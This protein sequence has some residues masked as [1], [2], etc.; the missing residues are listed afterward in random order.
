MKKLIL[1]LLLA[2]SLAACSSTEMVDGISDP[3]EK[4]N[5]K[6]H[7]VN[8][9]LD[10]AL[11]KPASG[12]YGTLVPD[13]L[14]K[15]FSNVANTLSL[16]GSVVNNVLQLRFDE[17]V[18]NTL[19]FTVNA[20]FGIGGLM[21]VAG[22]FGLDEH[23]TDF[24]ETLHRWGVGEGSYIVLPL[25]GPSTQRDS[26]GLLVDMA[27]DPVSLLESGINDYKLPLTMADLADARTRY[28]DL[29][30]SVIYESADSYAQMRVTYLDRRRFELVAPLGG[31]KTN[32]DGADGGAVSYD[33]YEDFYE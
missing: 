23:D 3:Y 17:A 4:T 8:V 26:I 29:Y 13:P 32:A 6:T 31:S 33:I 12:A 5:R 1:S 20:T 18:Y 28:S 27:L 9:S 11:I 14:R 30:E 2:T 16:P 25:Y 24:G 22:A 7:A 15:G 19:R 21:D 10:R